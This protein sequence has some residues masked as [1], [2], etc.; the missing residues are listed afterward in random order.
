MDGNGQSG[1]LR[2]VNLNTW[3]IVGGFMATFAGIVTSY[4]NLQSE[5]RDFGKF[6]EEQR[7]VN[8]RNDQRD[9]TQDTILDELPLMRANVAALAEAD[10]Q[11]D[12]RMGRFSESYSNQFT[13]FRGQ[14][15]ALLTQNALMKQSLDRIE[16]WQDSWRADRRAERNT[17][18]GPTSR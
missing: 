6:V 8:A 18:S 12:D 1:I 9:D 3:V 17:P 5:Q 7:A 4:N 11:T 2:G 15:S 14:L 10:K 13:E 16:A